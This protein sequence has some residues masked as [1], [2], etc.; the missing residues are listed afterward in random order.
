MYIE[1]LI[2]LLSMK[3]QMNP[4]DSKVVH[5]F[6]DQI[7]RGIGFTEK[8][9]QLAVKIV[10]RHLT[11]LS[12]IS[13]MDILQFT[14][15]PTFRLASRKITTE[16]RIS[17]INH[18]QFT[19]AIKVEFPYNESIV[20][21]IRK[22]RINLPFAA[23]DKDEKAWIFSL[24]EASVNLLM[25]I[26]NIDE[27]HSDDEYK[28]YVS[29][30]EDVKNKIDQYVPMLTMINGSPKIV[31]VIDS[32]PQPNTADVLESLF[33]ARKVG[34][35]TWDESITEQL[36]DISPQSLIYKF[37]DN[38]PNK[39]F[40]VN[41]EETPFSDLENIVKHLFPTIFIIPGGSELEK[42]EMTLEFLKNLG[43]SNQEISVL[44]RLP[45]ETGEKFNVF[46]KNNELN[47][48]IT[49]NTKAIFIC[50][51]VPKT[52]IESKIKFNSVVNHSVYSV[53]YTIRE[54]VKYHHNVINIIEKKQQ[55]SL[56]FAFM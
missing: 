34:V 19:K 14:E 51:K 56:N 5:S 1:D 11:K 29:Q 33:F 45:N 43:V 44:F 24:S 31:N 8:Q 35:S 18:P 9:S 42:T 41:L 15:N 38:T 55:R 20:E 49:E 50:G 22:E 32:V 21:I 26:F 23:W 40:E 36:K 54:F 7:S 16:Q 10:K 52:V 4:F 25:S 53:H 46:V 3:C 17:I 39:N 37:L 47:G 6:H 48:P 27:I 2:I 30:I 12:T 13:G 28:N